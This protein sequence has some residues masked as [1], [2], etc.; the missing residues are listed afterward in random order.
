MRQIQIFVLALLMTLLAGCSP[1]YNWREVSVDDGVGM[2]LFPDKPRTHTRALQFSGHDVSFN[3]TTVDVGD[4]IFAVGHARWPAAMAGDPALRESMG[5]T[6]IASLYRNLGLEAPVELP[7]FG[8]R[9][10]LQGGK[11]GSM[12][13]QAQVWVADTGL[14]EGLVMGPA[15]GFEHES[16]RQFLD[17]LAKTR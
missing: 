13:L 16:A 5:Q 1:E 9:F 11:S 6:V 10:E 3:L 14:V 7:E 12:L 15:D 4:T 2:V 17:S 8:Q